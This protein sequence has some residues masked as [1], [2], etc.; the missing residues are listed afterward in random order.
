MSN[1]ENK[2]RR[3]SK[4]VEAREAELRANAY[5]N[6]FM[7]TALAICNNY[8]NENISY[9]G[10]ANNMSKQMHEI[11]NNTIHLETMLFTQAVALQEL[12]N[13]SMTQA[14]HSSTIAGLKA[15]SEIALRAQAQSRKTIATLAEIKNPR[16]FPIFVRQQNNA[17][18]QQ[19][20]NEKTTTSTDNLNSAN[21]LNE[22]I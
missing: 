21:E 15:W 10:L 7:S 1:S 12:F 18:N 13:K 22:E 19:I 14:S 5:S 11:K 2:L 6:P 17:I 20:N 4:T 16:N 9:E 3:S 8:K